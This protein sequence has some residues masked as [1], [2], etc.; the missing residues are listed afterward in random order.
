MQATSAA[1]WPNCLTWARPVLEIRELAIAGVFELTARRFADERG[2]FTESWNRQR[3]EDAGLTFDWS[4]DNHAFSAA[5]G[6]LRGLHFQKPPFAQTKLVR[7]LRGRIYDVALDLR[8]GSPDYGT[9]VGL[10]LSAEAGNQIL[11]PKGFAHGY[12]TLEPDCEVAYK[13]DA[14]Y[15]RDHEGSLRYDDPEVAV[16][17]PDA[18]KI[19]LSEKDAAAPLLADL[20]RV[21]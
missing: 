6:V 17:W 19:L 11:V 7:C 1:G 2:W 3:F 16:A 8:A 5:A 12:L 4:Q 20:G 21:F 15:A 14:P 18:D 13:V 10:E 9:Y